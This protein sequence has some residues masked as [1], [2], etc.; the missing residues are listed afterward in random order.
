MTPGARLEAVI[1]ILERVWADNQAA[2]RV[3]DMYFKK[4][5]YAG[6]S[7]RRA[8]QATLYDILRHRS[9]LDWWVERSG[10]SLNTLSRTRIIANLILSEKASSNEISSLFSGLGHSP[11]V[12]SKIEHRLSKDLNGKSLNHA[13]MPS[14]V[15]LEYPSWMYAS[16]LAV[17]G[18]RL[19]TEI[20]AL[21]KTA[22]VDIRVNTLKSTVAAAKAE[23]ECQLIETENTPLSP[24]GLR[25]ISKVR[26]AG[27][28][29]FRNGLI[30]VQD[31]GS[32]ILALLCNVE[33]GM[34]VV[35]YCAGAGG[36]TLALA[37][38]MGFEG[39]IDGQ[40]FACDIS[41]SRINRME[42]R[43]QR[44]G[45]TAV[46]CKLLTGKDDPWMEEN[47]SS[48]DR[49][50]VDVPCTGTGA[51]RRDPNAK[52]RLKP[53]QL[54]VFCAQQ[55]K[56]LVDSATLVKLGG[57][58]IYATC[59]MLYEENEQQLLD[60]LKYNNGFTSIPI[61]QVWAETIGQSPP[62]TGPYLRLSPASTG[63]DGFF[64]AVLERV[65]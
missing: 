34:L 53:E 38:S 31:E 6:S 13:D 47:K 3:A 18:D 1:E 45:A 59:S 61:D 16:F 62:P 11:H 37:A 43:L 35:D 30:E 12:L 27:T 54:D 29:A 10:L 17:W 58:L 48:I 28:R 46:H 25:L 42:P 32:Q 49:V 64:C 23:L 20:L 56:I 9:R 57:R 15:A 51:W 39:R 5:R 55:R 41:Q 24:I 36:K 19:K 2:D 14:A 60:F 44:A 21:N 52:W 63:T 8:I 26:L 7:D 22:P 40:L 4:R 33:P 50:L 65:Q